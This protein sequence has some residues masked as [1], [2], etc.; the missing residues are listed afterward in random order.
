MTD[1]VKAYVVFG[2][3]D[4]RVV[5]VDPL[6]VEPGDVVLRTRATAICTTE[7]RLYEGTLKIPYPVIAGHEVSGVVE[8]VADAESGLAPG[9]HVVIDAVNRCGRCRFCIRGQSNLCP[10]IYTSKREGY[11]IVGGGFA[12][13]VT[14]EANRLFKITGEVSHEEAALTEPLACCVHSV[15]RAGLQLGDTVAIIG[16]GTMGLLHVLVAKLHGAKVVVSDLD[17]RRLELA[18]RLGADWTINPAE[19]DPAAFI[20]ERNDGLGA[21]IVFIAASVRVAGQQ[22]L[23]MVERGGR[24]VF[25][26]S[27]HPP[28][29]LDVDWNLL[30]HKEVSL[31][32][33]VGKLQEEFRQAAALIS[34]RAVD[35]RPLVTRT[36]SLDGLSEE[37]GLRPAGD[38]QRVVLTFR[39]P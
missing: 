39:E 15:K 21:D 25:F 26:A 22:A 35:L 3:R 12:D 34:S 2:A 24:V 7:R 14:V 4:G 6:K 17:E 9:D 1:K 37:L 36:I 27:T 20:K 32:G 11:R 19:I 23:A 30:H 8:S 13:Q 29:R 28:E 31:V 16:A 18:R 5:E 10:R 33:S 38:T